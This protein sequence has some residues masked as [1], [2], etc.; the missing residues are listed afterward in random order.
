MKLK[1][2]TR[3]I[4]TMVIIQAIVL[5]IL[6]WNNLRTF[7]QTHTERQELT[8]ITEQ[9]YLVQTLS[10]GLIYADRAM[11]NE[12]LLHLK[13][14]SDFDYAVVTDRKNRIMASAG[15]VPS[16]L[17]QVKFNGSYENALNFG[18]FHLSSDV[19]KDNLFLG[20][21][22]IGFSTTEVKQIL[23]DA[24]TQNIIL[25]LIAI[26]LSLIA[27]IVLGQYITSNLRLLENGAKHFAEGDLHYRINKVNDNTIDDVANAFNSLAENLQQNID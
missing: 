3:L 6:F 17:S 12:S 21:F 22:Y 9:G 16:D 10:L 14:R 4:I 5:I 7:E 23:H 2:S 19:H 11:L 13:A 18:V 15:N 26:T 27:S 25:S 24:R 8:Y 1:L 20:S